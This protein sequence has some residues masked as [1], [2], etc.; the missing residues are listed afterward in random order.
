VKT[1]RIC[2][3]AGSRDVPLRLAHRRSSDPQTLKQDRYAH[4]LTKRSTEWCMD[5]QLVPHMQ[6]EGPV[7]PDRVMTNSMEE[8]GGPNGDSWIAMLSFVL[9]L[10]GVGAI[11]FI[12]R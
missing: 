9:L 6:G 7:E 5:V 2:L 1:K 4:T 10:A 3:L 12:F 8:E 11:A